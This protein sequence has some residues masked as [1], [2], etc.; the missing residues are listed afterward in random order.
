MWKFISRIIAGI[1]GLA[2]AIWFIPEITIRVLKDSNFFGIALTTQWHIIILLGLVLGA[3]NT[4]IKGALNLLNLP[5]RFLSTTA[6]SFVLNLLTVWAID[7]IFREIS[8]PWLWPVIETTLI[9]WVLMI[10]LPLLL[11]RKKRQII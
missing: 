2:V 3:I 11:S 5:I 4:L 1:L 6:L 8:I 9:I 10:I 7:L